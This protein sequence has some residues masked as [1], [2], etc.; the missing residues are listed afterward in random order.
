METETGD[1]CKCKKNMISK[2]HK[3]ISKKKKLYSV[4]GRQASV[5]VKTLGMIHI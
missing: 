2:L 3:Q 5:L 1:G 4:P